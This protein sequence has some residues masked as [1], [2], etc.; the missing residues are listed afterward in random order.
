VRVSRLH[1]DTELTAG[2]EL[3]LRGERARYLGKVLRARPGDRLVLFDGRGGEFEATVIGLA[4]E[5]VDLAIG[6]RREVD[7]ESPLAVT[8]GLGISRGERMDYALQK[9]TELGVAAI[10]P[11]LTERCVVQLDAERAAGRA[12]HWGGVIASA[13]E[14]C[15]RNRVPVL[16]PVSGL[17]EWLAVG[18]GGLRLVLS[19]AAD[20]ALGDLAPPRAGLTLL[21]GPEGGLEPAELAL[22][23]R[24]GF[25]ALRLGPR[26]LRTE[27]AVVAALAAIQA[28]WGD[29][30]GA[31]HT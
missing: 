3:A 8:L 30:A 23:A 5:R 12:A 26:V 15:G 20:A 13:C 27:T 16:A 25:R 7:R 31:V 9:A 14:Q 19:P 28:C 17:T 1:V 24:A 2:A 11:L 18:P 6:V 29:L 10:V 22:A 4:R 21:I